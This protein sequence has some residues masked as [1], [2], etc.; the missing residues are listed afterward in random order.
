MADF[1]KIE[2]SELPAN[3]SN[4]I[5]ASGTHRV[6]T[7]FVPI[8]YQGVIMGFADACKSLHD[9]NA[10]VGIILRD[11]PL[12]GEF[13]FGVKV[14]FIPGNEEDSGSWNTVWS[15][16][17]DDFN[18]CEI[19]HYVDEANTM[20]IFYDRI[21]KQGLALYPIENVAYT[22]TRVA[23]QSL[24]QWLDVNAKEG[25][26]TAI[27]SEGYFKATVDVVDG[28]KVMNLIPDEEVTNLAKSDGEISN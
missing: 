10:T 25:E 13:I 5:E 22:L 18:D 1:I 12:D 20:P 21:V 19:K 23:M 24:F 4:A 26:Q 17:P 8:I 11:R 27:G 14:A 6:G 7:E 28:L 15:F 9:K 2:G 16:N 3:Y